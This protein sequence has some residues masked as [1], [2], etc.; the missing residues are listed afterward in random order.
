MLIMSIT[1]QNSTQ[2]DDELMELFDISSPGLH[3]VVLLDFEPAFN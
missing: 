1:L 3:Q 2:M